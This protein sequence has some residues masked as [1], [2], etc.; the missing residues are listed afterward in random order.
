VKRT[1]YQGEKIPAGY[2]VAFIDPAANRLECYPVPLHLLVRAAR[3]AWY[4]IAGHHSGL[5]DEHAAF[6]A[7]RRAFLEGVECGRQN[8]QA[9]IVMEIAKRGDV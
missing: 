4:W 3:R 7:A 6:E 5:V 9:R 1:V 8:E 2:G